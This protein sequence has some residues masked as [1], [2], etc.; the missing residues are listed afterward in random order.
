MN[1]RSDHGDD[2]DGKIRSENVGIEEAEEGQE[3]EQVAFGQRLGK[4]PARHVR[5]FVVR[6]SRRRNADLRL[7]VSR[8]KLAAEKQNFFVRRRRRPRSHVRSIILF[9][10]TRATRT[11]TELTIFLFLF[12]L[13]QRGKKYTIV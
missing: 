5:S 11:T 8:E 6:E 2:G 3:T 10:L 9:Y 1:R 12:F 4:I 13:R 7:E